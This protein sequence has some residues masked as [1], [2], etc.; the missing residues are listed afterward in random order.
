MA[1]P[2]QPILDLGIKGEQMQSNHNG[3][4]PFVLMQAMDDLPPGMAVSHGRA[5]PH[6]LRWV[7][8]LLPLDGE[9]AAQEA[10]EQ[11]SANG[12]EEGMRWLLVLIFCF[13]A[14]GCKCHNTPEK[15]WKL[16]CPYCGKVVYDSPP[17]PE[18]DQIDREHINNCPE[19]R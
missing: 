4:L 1:E 13:V 12:E 16:G 10:A 15:K 17:W 14:I 3:M 11:G 2:H 8:P 9:Q 7:P 5:D 18:G 6:R 19:K